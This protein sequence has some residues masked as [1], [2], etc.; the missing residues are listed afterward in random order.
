MSGRSAR[1]FGV[2]ALVCLVPT[3]A[4]AQATVPSVRLSELPLAEGQTGTQTV[5]SSEGYPVFAVPPIEITAPYPDAAARR[6]HERR[7]RKYTKLEQRIRKVYP[8]AQACARVVRQVDAEMAR[9]DKKADQKA[10]AKALEKELFETYEP[11]LR[12]LTL[13]E[14]KVLL[15]LIDR[16]TG[17]SAY[18]LIKHYKS[19]TSAVF[20]QL[21]AKVFGAD[22]KENYNAEE[23]YA[24]ETI[25]YHL[26][27]EAAVARAQ[28]QH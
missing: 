14:G 19:G 26:E 11:V 2:L 23:E 17:A 28:A 7:M 25:L 4:L 27:Y 24:F 5:P 10:Y 1:A 8:I 13:S 6:Q 20:W 9:L 16:Q 21:V 12:K 3:W 22:L 15:K 18:E